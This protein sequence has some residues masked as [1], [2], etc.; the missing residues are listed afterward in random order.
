MKI[1]VIGA[2][3]FVGSAVS[4]YLAVK[5]HSV[6]R[7]VGPSDR[8]SCGDAR[9]DL[10]EEDP[11]KGVEGHEMFDAV[12]NCSGIAHRTGRVADRD[13]TQINVEGARK[14]AQFAAES[15]ATSLIHLSSVLVYGNQLGA[16]PVDETAQP[17]P[18]D[19]YARS[20]L[21]GE[22]AVVKACA[23]RGLRLV[24]LRP[25]PIIGEGGKGNVSRLIRA[26]DRRRFIWIGNGNNRRSLVYVE[27]VAR[28]TDLA[29]KATGFHSIFNVV[30]G[31]ATMAEIVAVISDRL[32]RKIWR[33]KVPVPLATAAMSVLSAGS[34]FP[35]IRNY[36]LTLD[37]WLADA[38]FSGEAIRKELG[39]AASTSVADGL[40]RQVDDYLL[41]K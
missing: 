8:E 27:D 39:F 35:Q 19:T 25:A 13:F 26:I 37:S 2:S 32:E 12:V 40:Q 10:S 22:N 9:I 15:G 17:T 34:L 29:L 28:A 30:G 5:G 21:E 41:T 7:G 3:G 16:S 4:R 23:D 36:R 20:K 38:V 33:A 31:S 1:F 14:V 18:R 24:V 11:F 6:F